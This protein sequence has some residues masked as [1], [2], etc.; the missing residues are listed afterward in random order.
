M[1]WSAQ[2]QQWVN[3]NDNGFFLTGFVKKNLRVM[4]GCASTSVSEK[5]RDTSGTFNG[6]WKVDVAKGSAIQYIQRWQMS[7][8]DLEHTFYIEVKDGVVNLAG[9]QVEEKTFI[10]AD[11]QFKMVVPVKSMATSNV[12]S[13]STFTDGSMRI[14]LAGTL[15]DNS[16]KA[17]GRMTYG[18]ADFGYDG[19]KSTASFIKS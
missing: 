10:S 15:S 9:Q 1:G 8:G 7:C 6:I 3:F 12:N 19:C 11:G 2:S 14:I 16:K 13:G 17:K 5:D 4:M 18:I